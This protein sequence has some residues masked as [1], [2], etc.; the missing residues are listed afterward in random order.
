MIL[1]APTDP[2]PLSSPLYHSLP[3]SLTPIYPQA[4]FEG[5]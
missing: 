5:H 2:P 4:T 1:G 3:L